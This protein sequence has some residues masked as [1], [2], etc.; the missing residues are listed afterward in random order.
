[1]SVV[2]TDQGFAPD[3]IREAVFEIDTTTP[4]AALEECLTQARVHIHA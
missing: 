3:L 4:V 2:V 1:M